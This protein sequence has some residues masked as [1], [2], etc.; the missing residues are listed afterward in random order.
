MQPNDVQTYC[1]RCGEP[2]A[3]RD[4]DHTACRAARGLEPPR[5]CGHCRRR[6]IVQVTPVGWTA[7][8]AEHGDLHG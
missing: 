6:M 4:A 7:R 1:D 5:Y 3:S 8:C 2:A